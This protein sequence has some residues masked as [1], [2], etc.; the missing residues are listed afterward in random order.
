MYGWEC[1]YHYKAKQFV[2][3]N[4]Q[5]KNFFRTRTHQSSTQLTR[6]ETAVVAHSIIY[7]H[8]RV[9][10]VYI[11][12]MYIARERK[13]KRNVFFFLYLSDS[14]EESEVW[15]WEMEWRVCVAIRLLV[16]AHEDDA[17]DIANEKAIREWR[18]C[19]RASS[20][21]RRRVLLH[22]HCRRAEIYT[23]DRQTPAKS[24]KKSSPSKQSFFF[25]FL[26]I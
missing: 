3:T 18:A 10:R 13:K 25:F 8:K 23:I 9:M 21:R 26:S 1:R 24:E 17:R 7:P 6:L 11:K 14:A 19:A 20:R 15:W 12:T 2:P 5:K 4:P 22:A 16:D